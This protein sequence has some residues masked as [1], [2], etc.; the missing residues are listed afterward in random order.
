[1]ETV[2]QLNN[3]KADLMKE[4]EKI[5]KKKPLLANMTQLQSIM[6]K[7][8]PEPSPRKQQSA[9]S[10]KR[11]RFEEEYVIPEP[12]RHEYFDSS[13]S[14]F[15]GQVNSQGKHAESK[16]PLIPVDDKASKVRN[17][18][19]ENIYRMFGITA[20]PVS[21]P[22]KNTKR[23]LLGIRIEIFNET[24]LK[25]ETP[26]YIIL[27]RN[28]KS[29][30]WDIFKHTIPVFIQIHEISKEFDDLSDDELF[31]FLERIRHILNKTSFKHQVVENIRNKYPRNVVGIEKDIAL[32][33]LK[34]RLKVAD[35]STIV[36]LSLSLDLIESCH[37]ESGFTE[38]EK[39][40]INNVIKG[41][42]T[43]FEK[44][45]DDVI[46]SLESV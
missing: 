15:F 5:K 30:K 39:F 20:F 14:K 21:D 45:I 2:A 26:H 44:K 12:A 18:I 28:Q 9:V 31:G 17:I 19:L 23:D 36:I 25:F 1:M 16:A 43:T 3:R 42:I 7:S 40:R 41:D 11:R 33:T 32:D 38:S 8:I 4:I 10:K 35:V 37:I 34:F 22:S 13:I 6:A 46:R 29:G 27:Q 24:L